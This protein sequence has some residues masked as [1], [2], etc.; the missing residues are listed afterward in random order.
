M[1]THDGCRFCA[2]WDLVQ[3]IEAVCEHFES[4]VLVFIDP[5]IERNYAEGT[6][7][8][9]KSTNKLTT[10]E[11]PQIDNS[12]PLRGAH[13]RRSLAFLVPLLARS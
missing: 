8:V 12:K 9:Y 3:E 6:R 5:R 7:L 13:F 10:R 2:G 4:Y 1:M 11:R